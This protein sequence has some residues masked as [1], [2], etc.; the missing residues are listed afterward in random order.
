MYVIVNGFRLPN[1]L[2]IFINLQ[3]LDISLIKLASMYVIIDIEMHE[4]L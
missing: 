4:A 1:N 3:T 2:D